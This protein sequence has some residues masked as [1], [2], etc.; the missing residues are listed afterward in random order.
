MKTKKETLVVNISSTK[1]I[2]IEDAEKEVKEATE[3]FS[4]ALQG[5]SEEYQIVIDLV[6]TTQA[7][8][9]ET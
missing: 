9:L 1:D 2:N 7:V 3:A 6:V 4:L 8:S 5:L